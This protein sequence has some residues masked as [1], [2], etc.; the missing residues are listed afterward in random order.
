MERVLL[1]RTHAL[2][3]LG[4]MR[5]CW[6]PGPLASLC[7]GSSLEAMIAVGSAEG[8]LDSGGR[9]TKWRISAAEV[10]T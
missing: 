7:G 6:T 8:S 1:Q 10:P 9:S 5:I 3:I 4:S 2:Y